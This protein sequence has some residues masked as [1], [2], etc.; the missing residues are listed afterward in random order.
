M[1]IY[2][3]MVMRYAYIF[4]LKNPTAFEDDFWS[5]F[6]VIW[7]HAVSIL[8]QVAWHCLVTYQPLEFYVCTGQDPQEMLQNPFL[9]F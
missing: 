2:A 6:I 7:I 9:M 3:A 1:Y 8:T 5:T 4:W